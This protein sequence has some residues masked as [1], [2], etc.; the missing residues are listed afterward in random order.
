MQKQNLILIGG[1]GHCVSVIDVIEAENKFEIIGILDTGKNI[2]EKVL[3]YS[4][5]GTDADYVKYNDYNT[6]FLITVGQIKTNGIR[7]AI[8]NSLINAK[9]ATVISPFAYVSKHATVGEGTII[10]HHTLV[11]AGVTIGKNCIINTKANIE[12]GARIGNFC[13]I[14][15]GAIVNGDCVINDG[16]FIGSNATIKQGLVI[17]ENTIIAAGEF[18]KYV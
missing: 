9:L 2:G 10:M 13:H 8:A 12:H 1:G 7:V 11:N 18:I 17:P 5:L 3:G 14:S 16:V 15:T 4:I 6:Y